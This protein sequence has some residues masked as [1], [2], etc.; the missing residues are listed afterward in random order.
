[1]GIDLTLL[2]VDEETREEGRR[3]Y[4]VRRQ[5]GL[6]RSYAA[7]QQLDFTRKVFGEEA[8][9]V[10]RGYKFSEDVVVRFEK[11]ETN[12]YVGTDAY[13]ADLKEICPSVLLPAFT[14]ARSPARTYVLLGEVASTQKIVLY[15]H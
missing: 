2:V 14:L 13:G 12:L 15:W 9:P 7:F 4:H 3:V 6:P 5:Y 8:N 10:L 11:R 1:M